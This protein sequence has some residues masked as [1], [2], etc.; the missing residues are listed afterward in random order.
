VTLPREEDSGVDIDLSVYKALFLEES[1]HHLHALRGNLARLG[2]DP[3]DSAALREAQ[4]SA[5]TLKGMAYTMHYVELG[6]LGKRLENQFE[7]QPP[8][9]ADQIQNLRTGCDEFEKRL[10]RLSEAA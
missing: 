4:R 6:D 5:H 2:N 3:M 7:S 1:W 9:T 10:R 8:L